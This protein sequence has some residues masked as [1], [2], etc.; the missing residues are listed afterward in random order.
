MPRTF[1]GPWAEN[2]KDYANNGNA[3]LGRFPLGH[4]LILP[5]E[6]Q[7]RFALND[8]TVEVAGSLYQSVVGIAGTTDMTADVV[9]AIGATAISATTSGSTT[10]GVDTYAEGAAHTS[11]DV[12]EGYTYRIRRAMTAG[13]AHASAASAAVLTVNLEPGESVQVA[14]DTTSEVTFTRNRY[15]AVLIT[16]APPTATLVGVSPGVAA[17]SRFY[18]SQV[19]GYAAVLAS[20]TLYQ[21]LPVQAG[22]TTAGTIESLKRRLQVT[23]T[24]SVLSAVSVFQGVVNDSAGAATALLMGV[25]VSTT[26]TTVFDATGGIANNAPIVGLCVKANSTTQ[27]ALIDL[28]II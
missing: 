8:A 23:T 17:A 10:Y 24:G 12:G 28:N 11:N 7:Y 18:W 1:Y 3:N 22:I 25:S 26:A 16:A 13:A 5:D 20:G 4:V 21:G 27:H 2:Y 14:L 19:K 15:H 9:R 6:R